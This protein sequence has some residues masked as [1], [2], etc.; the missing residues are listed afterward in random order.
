[1]CDT[2]VALGNATLDGSVIFAK[3]SDREPNE[4]HHILIMPAAEYPHGSMVQCTYVQIPRSNIRML[5]C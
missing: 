2:L 3:N 1:M 4:A 5:S